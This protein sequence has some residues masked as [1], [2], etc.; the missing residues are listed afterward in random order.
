VEDHIHSPL[1]GDV[2]GSI[3]ISLMDL[4][5]AGR[6]FSARYGRVIGWGR[7][8]RPEDLRTLKSVS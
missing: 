4:I 8:R 5:R 7:V 1:H 2:P 6:D 3:K